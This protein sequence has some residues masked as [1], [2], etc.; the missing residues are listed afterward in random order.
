MLIYASNHQNEKRQT[1]LPLFFGDAPQDDKT[2]TLSPYDF[3]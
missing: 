3:M 1:L 2:S